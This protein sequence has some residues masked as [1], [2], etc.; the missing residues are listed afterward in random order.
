MPCTDKEDCK[1]QSEQSSSSLA[2]TDHS[3]HDQDEEHCPPFCVCTCC[4]Q[5]FSTDFL[6]SFIPFIVAPSSEDFPIYTS[7]FVSEVYFNIWQPPKIS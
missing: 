2:D 5:T 7:A 3:N 6:Y 1:Y 4:G